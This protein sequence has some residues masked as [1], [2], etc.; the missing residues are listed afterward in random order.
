MRWSEALCKFGVEAAMTFE[1]FASG[2]GREIQKESQWAT[3][4][5]LRK[6]SSPHGHVIVFKP[7]YHDLSRHGRPSTR[8]GES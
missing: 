5:R 6:N 8:R 7:K 4:A 3:W 1:I 2:H